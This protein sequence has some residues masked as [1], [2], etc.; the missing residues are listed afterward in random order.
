VVYVYADEVALF[1]EVEDDAGR[2]LAR[3]YAFHIP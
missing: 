3:V 2:Y 1:V